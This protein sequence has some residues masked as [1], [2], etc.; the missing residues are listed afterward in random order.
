MNVNKNNSQLYS[1]W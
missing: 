1:K